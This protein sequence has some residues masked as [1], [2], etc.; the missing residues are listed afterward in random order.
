MTAERSAYAILGLRPGAGRAEVNDAYRRL[1]KRHHPDRPGGDANRAAEINRAYT[2]LRRRLGEPVRVPVTI[3]LRRRP[4][5]ARF[6]RLAWLFTLGVIGISLALANR[7]AQ[8]ST[9]RPAFPVFSE[10]SNSTV[11]DDD[12]PYEAPVASFDEPV[13]PGIVSRAVADA[14][15]F[16]SSGDVSGASAYS[17]DCQ[18]T[19]RRERNL[20]WFDACSAFD[21]AMLTL[22][23][24]SGQPDSSPFNQ[25]AVVSREIAAARILSD[26]SLSV[27]SHLHQIRSQVDMEI[28]PML[29]SAAAVQR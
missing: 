3:P 23:G 27:D 17:R 14:V 13:Q 1:M 5:P 16:R 22:Y 21:E 7:D 11:S 29:D 12:V 4:P 10:W 15:R 2:F 19:L 28:L 9:A 20:G 24:D 6:R 8:R 18:V 26:D 25:A